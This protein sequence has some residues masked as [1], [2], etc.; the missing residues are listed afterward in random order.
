MA[1]QFTREELAQLASAFRDMM[2]DFQPE[3]ELRFR[4]EPL[5]AVDEVV[6]DGQISY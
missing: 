5:L 3:P 1:A 2:M 4:Y 6:A